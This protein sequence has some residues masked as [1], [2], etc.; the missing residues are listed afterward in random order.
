[1][2]VQLKIKAKARHRSDG[3]YEIRPLIDGKRISIYG[4]TA[5]AIAK[6]Y[7]KALTARSKAPKNEKKVKI[8]LY[9]WL[10]EW[11]DV[12][13]KPNVAQNTYNNLRRCVE[14]HLKGTLEDKALTAYTLTEL[15]AALNRIETTR[16]RKYARGTLMAALACAVTAG[17]SR[18]LPLTSGVG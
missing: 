3:L 12:Y 13:K 16:M 15:T 7:E 5:E 1:M 18:P 8:S 10:D 2:L 14:K 11:L 4:K 6:K 9:A 17:H